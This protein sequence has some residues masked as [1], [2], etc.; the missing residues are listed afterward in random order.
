MKKKST[1]RAKKSVRARFL[2]AFISAGFIFAFHCGMGSAPRSFRFSW[3]AP[4]RK[5]ISACRRKPSCLGNTCFFI[6]GSP[7]LP[8]RKKTFPAILYVGLT[9]MSYK[10]KRKQKRKGSV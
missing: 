6:W 9:M 2:P 1:Q 10:I 8:D 7:L 3:T 5:L 4:E